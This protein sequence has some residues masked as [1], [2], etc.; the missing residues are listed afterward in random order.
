MGVSHS[1]AQPSDFVNNNPVGIEIVSAIHD[2][3][4]PFGSYTIAKTLKETGHDKA[5]FLSDNSSFNSLLKNW[6]NEMFNSDA[7]ITSLKDVKPFVFPL[8]IRPNDDSKAFSAGLTSHSELKEL[9]I[10]AEKSNNSYLNSEILVVI[11]TPKKIDLEVRLFIAD[12]KVIGKTTYR[13]GKMPFCTDNVDSYIV[14]YGE[15]IANV[16]SPERLYVLDIAITD[17]VPKILEVNTI[18]ASSLYAVN[19]QKLIEGIESL[20][21]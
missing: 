8:F 14:E 16:W 13:R 3:I 4:F 9:Q 17:G 20:N 6:G 7:I 10:V 18:H 21:L 2:T 11:A 5:V 15:N 1:F 19:V 12:R